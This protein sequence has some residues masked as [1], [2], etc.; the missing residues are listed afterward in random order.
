M[1]DLHVAQA[2]VWT[3]IVIAVGL[4]IKCVYMADHID[5][6]K[7]QI[8]NANKCYKTAVNMLGIK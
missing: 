4:A 8:A 1:I 3:L 2:V 5:R 6:L 7:L